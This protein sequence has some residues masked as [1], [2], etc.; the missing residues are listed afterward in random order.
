MVDTEDLEYYR[1]GGSVRDPLIDREPNDDDYVV[2]GESVESMVERGFE[3]EIG[4]AFTVFQHPETKD[5]WAMARTEEKTGEGYK[6]FD[7]KATPSVT[8]EEDLERRDLTINA[9]ARDPRTGEL[10]DPYGGQEDLEK[11]II[12]HVSEAFSDDPLRVIRA[13]R[14]AARFE[15]TV[16]DE[17]MDLMREVAPELEAVDDLRIYREIKKALEQA[18]KPRRIFDVLLKS[19]GLEVV[20]PEIAKLDEVPAGPKEAHR[21][22]SAFEHTMQ[23]LEEMHKLRPNDTRALFAALF[24]DIG[25]AQTPEEELPH[26]YGHEKRGQKIAEK[27][28]DRLDIPNDITGVIKSASRHH[29][30]VHDLSELRESTL[31][32]RVEKFR[33]NYSKDHPDD[34]VSPKHITLGELIDLGYAD[35][36]GRKP[37]KPFDREEAHQ[38]IDTV[39]E[40]IDSIKGTDIIKKY[41]V[42]EGEVIGKL[43]LQE[44]V[45]A[46]KEARTTN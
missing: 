25:K 12:R 45:E 34:E 9:M 16:A 46:L 22:G 18:E 41:D 42:E 11:G 8:L 31:I 7:I 23:V 35:S 40:I 15:F 36:K 10:I 33:D 19:G 1:V 21:E 13:A 20:L 28:A 30:V 43:I 27:I 26:H 39:K 2:V 32:R 14:F 44:R 3:K 5:E 37:S 6:G 29:M 4:A 38:I 17:T 24:H